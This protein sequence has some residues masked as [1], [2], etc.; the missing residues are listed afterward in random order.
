MPEGDRD[1]RGVALGAAAAILWVVLAVRWFDVAAPWRPSWLE[2]IPPL[3]LALPA[4]VAVGGWLRSRAPLLLGEPLGDSRM[5]LVL[6]LALAFFF[7]LPTAWRGAAATVTPDGALSGIVALHLRDGV[8][9]LVFVPLVPYSGSLKSH[10]AAAFAVVIDPARAFVLASVVFYVAYVAGLFLLARLVGGRGAAILA[11]VYAAFAPAFVTRYSLSNDGNYVE[12][13]ALG[14]WALWLATL[15]AVEDRGR[16]TR[17]LLAGLLLGLAFWCHI[18]AVI[19]LAAVGAVLVLFGRTR[20]VRSLAWL[21]VGWG[22]GYAPGLLWNARNEWGSFQYLIPGAATGEGG[23]AGGGL[24]Q[25]AWAMVTDHWPVLLGYDAGYAQP[26]DSVLRI[27]AWAA[28]LLCIGA[29]GR[30]AAR[31]LRTGSRPL[32]VLLI[33]TVVNLGV[34]LLSLPH[35]A[36]NPRYLLFLM[37]PLPVFL[38]DALRQGRGRLVFVG[39]VA[40][41]ALG[42]LGHLPGTLRADL[43]WRELTEGLEREGV[44]FCYTDFHLATRIN[45]ISGEAVVC[46][47]KLGPVTTEYFLSYRE[48]VE[49]A[50]EAALV[51]VNTYSADRMGKRLEALGVTYERRDF[52][53]PVLLRLSRKV[54]PEEL[55]PGRSFEPR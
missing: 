28:V 24:A 49:Q 47:A 43:R 23:G 26:I 53:K 27:L 2:A 31:A 21:G 25:K 9:R 17:A 13:L 40:L 44:R 3:V 45:F 30:A 20:A 15:W 39:L 41:G 48:R 54:E 6:V 8:E 55:F 5:A 37:A 19:H 42:S 46:S 38:A 50:P 35:V 14:T 36:G 11:G 12:V 7:R 34:A 29:T 51:A 4:F 16:E 52:M 32:T 10:L 33:F 22:L 1:R 18:L